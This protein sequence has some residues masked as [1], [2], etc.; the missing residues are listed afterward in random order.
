METAKYKQQQ[1]QQN[2]NPQSGWG[3]N[4]PEQN[5]VVFSKNISDGSISVIPPLPPHVDANGTPRAYNQ[6]VQN[7][8]NSAIG[9]GIGSNAVH[10][11][12]GNNT[13]SI[14]YNGN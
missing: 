13:G 11:A 8:Y 12:G 1:N 7:Q 4:S 2:Y 14:T 10:D 3:Q 6:D 9:N 5:G